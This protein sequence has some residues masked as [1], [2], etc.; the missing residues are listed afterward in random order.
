MAIKHLGV[1]KS[2][3]LPLLVSSVL[4][5]LGSTLPILWELGC[6][7]TIVPIEAVDIIRILALSIP[8]VGVY[9]YSRRI[10]GS[11]KE[12]VHHPRAALPRAA[13]DRAG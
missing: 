9:S 2:F 13:Q 1:G 3:W 7:L 11:L 10:K 8:T 12:E 5:T 6:L 4:F